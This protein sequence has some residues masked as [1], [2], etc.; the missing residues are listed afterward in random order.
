MNYLYFRSLKE[1]NSDLLFR[2]KEDLK[3]KQFQNECD[4]LFAT[5]LLYSAI[6]VWL[7]T[8]TLDNCELLND[9]YVGVS[10]HYF[11]IRGEKI[12]K[13]IL[14]FFP[15]LE[16]WFYKTAF[17]S[18]NFHPIN[19][20]RD[21]LIF[22][23]DIIDKGNKVKLSKQD[24]ISVNTDFSK[25]F[26]INLGKHDTFFG[27]S[28]V[29]HS[30]NPSSVFEHEVDYMNIFEQLLDKIEFYPENKKLEKKYYNPYIKVDS[31]YQSWSEI[32]PNCDIVLSKVGELYGTEIYYIEKSINDDLWTA[33]ITS[34]L[35]NT[36]LRN[37]IMFVLRFKYGNPIKV[38]IEK[39]KDNFVMQRY[40]ENFGGLEELFVQSYGWPQEK[41]NDMLNW[42]FPIEV[43]DIF[44][45]VLDKQYIKIKE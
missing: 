30:K 18:T 9:K 27:L 7:K 43:Y 2:I 6:I 13:D 8:I 39:F 16:Q 19:F 4:E 34:F 42:C 29:V 31:L 35:D 12:L 41:L 17:E 44:L 40:V 23:T 10:K 32:R 33:N 15:N 36:G 3:I 1:M 38:K 45:N 28:S 25:I 24:E 5:R 11:H 21:R 37:K 14:D 26:D 22:T 20:I